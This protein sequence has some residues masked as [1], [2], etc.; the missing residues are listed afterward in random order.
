L[1]SLPK[2]ADRAITQ[3]GKTE[4]RTQQFM[5]SVLAFLVQ[6]ALSN[7]DALFHQRR[8]SEI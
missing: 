1:G 7:E 8:R 4:N 3:P 2:T 6:R 5:L